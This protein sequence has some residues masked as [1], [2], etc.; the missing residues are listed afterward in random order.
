MSLY[1]ADMYRGIIE[2]APWAMKGTYL[3]QKIEQYQ[4]DKVFAAMGASGG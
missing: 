1:I 2:G 4:L 3:R